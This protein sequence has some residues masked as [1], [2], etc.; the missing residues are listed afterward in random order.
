MVAKKAVKKR[1]KKS[2]PEVEKAP[3]K[4]GLLPKAAKVEN[5]LASL[6]GEIPYEKGQPIWIINKNDKKGYSA[7]KVVEVISKVDMNGKDGPSLTL[8]IRIR[9]SVTPKR[10]RYSYE[11]SYQKQQTIPLAE[12][13]STFTTDFDEVKQLTVHGEIKS[14]K[15]NIATIRKKITAVKSKAARDVNKLESTIADIQKVI[16]EK[17][18]LL[19]VKPLKALKGAGKQPENQEE[20][21][22]VTGRMRMLDL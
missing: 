13:S 3:E 16:N 9:Y 11:R 18:V 4:E 5:E 21:N 10:R 12:A 8:Q 2:T 15:Q 14:L 22:T 6:I 17:K 20:E 19:S 7:G 1:T